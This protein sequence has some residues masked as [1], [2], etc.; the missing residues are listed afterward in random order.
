MLAIVAYLYL[1]NSPS[2]CRFLTA[3]QNHIISQRAIKGRGNDQK[4]AINFAQ[5]FAAFVDYKNYLQAIMIF[6]LNT[7]FGSLP[8]YLPTILKAIGYTS[9]NAQGLSAPPYVAAYFVCIAASYMSDRVQNR[10]FFIFGFCCVGGAGYTLLAT[11]SST[12][13]RYFS[14]FLVCAGVFP[15]VALT[16]VWVTDNQGSSPKRSAGLAIFRM[17]GQCGP[18][19]GARIFPA[20]DAPIYT[21]GMWVCAGVLFFAAYVTLVLSFSLRVQN[22][23]RDNRY[24]R[25]ELDHVPVDVADQGDA[26]PMYRFVL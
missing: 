15:A 4:G 1:P 9:L 10:S 19:L 16:F 21:N 26:H 7:A 11:F 23:R 24:G 18:I 3:R 22:R 5:V 14:T 20:T 6:C 17:V 2:E 25:S 8:A 12:G 13:L